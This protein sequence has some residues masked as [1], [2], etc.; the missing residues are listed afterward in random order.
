[1]YKLS[2]FRRFYLFDY[3]FKESKNLDDVLE[4]LV[5]KFKPLKIKD[6]ENIINDAK[7][8]GLLP[9]GF[10]DAVAMRSLAV[11]PPMIYF[12]LLQEDWKGGKIMLLE[13]K[14][15]WYSHDKIMLSMRTYCRNAGIKCRFLKYGKFGDAA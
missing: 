1:V 13:T 15:S 11:E 9:K 7:E 12:L 2:E 8:K 4:K 14:N 3:E 6:F 5:G 10:K